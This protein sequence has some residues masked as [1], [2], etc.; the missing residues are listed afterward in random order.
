MS[1]KP[2]RIGLVGYGFMGRTHS[3]GYNR[4]PNF[5][6]LECEPVLQAVCGRNKENAEAFAAKWGYASVETDWR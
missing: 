4:V 5:F 6:D 2:V 3:N 1:K